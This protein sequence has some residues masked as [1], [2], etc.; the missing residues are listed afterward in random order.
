VEG[1]GILKQPV[2]LRDKHIQIEYTEEDP[3]IRKFFE[4]ELA[5]SG[6]KS[7]MPPQCY[8]DR[9]FKWKG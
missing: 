4:S 2:R 9:K 5:K 3:E 7:K 6:L 8:T 1:E